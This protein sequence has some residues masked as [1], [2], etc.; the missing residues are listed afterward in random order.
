MSS[1]SNSDF[2]DI[3]NN[4]FALD[5]TE[6]TLHQQKAENARK[7]AGAAT[8]FQD[9]NGFLCLKFYCKN[10]PAESL[11]GEMLDA[12]NGA[13]PSGQI[14]D[15]ENYY[16]FEGRDMHGR[17]WTAE[18][19]QANSNANMS[20]GDMLFKAARIG[21]IRSEGENNYPQATQAIVVVKGKYQ[22]PFNQGQRGTTEPAF[23]KCEIKIDEERSAILRT[24]KGDLLVALKPGSEEPAKYKNRILEAIGIAVGALLKPQAELIIQSD[25]RTAV[26]YSA[27]TKQA[28]LNRL[29]SPIPTN[30]PDDFADFRDFV[31][32]YFF[33]NANPYQEIAGFW[34][35]ILSGFNS[36]AEN[37]GLIV[38][39]ACEGI[40]HA[41]FEEDS[42]PDSEFLN[43]CEEALK[44]IA[45]LPFKERA[46]S[47]II[48]SLKSAKKGTMANALRKL[49]DGG[50]IPKGLRVLWN[51]L[52][53]K[54]AHASELDWDGE[55][56]QKFI[57]E[58]YGCLELFYRLIML[59]IDYKGHLYCYS[60]F[61][62]PIALVFEDQAHTALNATSTD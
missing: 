41:C 1:L 47:R 3:A 14:I 28:S 21:S 62:W 9:E 20:T 5:F 42:F 57:N 34:F 32:R 61:G 43:Q 22:I 29:V 8:I 31:V 38:A 35:R 52:R 39:T 56:S 17:V 58:L 10:P 54:L 23:S 25:S 24:D 49:E 36:S 53:H 16:R 30:S 40:I 7:Y 15:S 27:Q 4:R 44:L 13:T 12:F 55:K 37:Q 26:V 50:R 46:G 59:H 60:R 33:A 19:V 18:H 6:A 11:C 51:D 2:E 45:D 48:Q